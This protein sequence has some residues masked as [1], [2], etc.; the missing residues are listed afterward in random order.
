MR[1]V[2]WRRWPRPDTVHVCRLS[3]NQSVVLWL[4]CGLQLS[5]PSSA[6]PTPQRR[7]VLASPSPLI[8]KDR[9]FSKRVVDN[10]AVQAGSFYQVQDT[11][12]TY[13]Y[14]ARPFAR[15]LTDE[16]RRRL[17]M[18]TSYSGDLEFFIPLSYCY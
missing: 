18:G 15:Q 10:T 16:G 17:V 12:G 1:A 6:I 4:C 13:R 8:S 2:C 11:Y 7:E 3:A 9:R 14:S 5:A